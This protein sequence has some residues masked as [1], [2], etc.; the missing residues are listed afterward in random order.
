[1][2]GTDDKDLTAQRSCWEASHSPLFV[3]QCLH[4][5]CCPDVLVVTHTLAHRPMHKVKTAVFL[6]KHHKMSL[7][8]YTEWGYNQRRNEFFTFEHCPFLLE[9]FYLKKLKK[10]NKKKTTHIVS[11]P[12]P[13]PP[14]P[15]KP[16]CCFLGPPKK[17][18]ARL[19]FLSFKHCV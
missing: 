13:T 17:Q 11:Y 10:K 8:F 1:M 7:D 2:T 5:T 9:T 15:T 16:N 6:Q 4:K 14:P 12:I 19:Y 18:D 3:K